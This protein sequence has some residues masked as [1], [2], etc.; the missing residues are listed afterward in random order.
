MDHLA[1]N[2]LIAVE[3]YLIPAKSVIVNLSDTPAFIGGRP[4][5]YLPARQSTVVENTELT[6]DLALSIALPSPKTSEQEFREAQWVDF[7]G[8]SAQGGANI[9]VLLKSPQTAVTEVE[10]DPYRATSGTSKRAEYFQIKLNLWFS[11]AGTDCGIHNQHDF[12]EVHTQIS[13]IGAMQKF[14]DPTAP[15]PYE[16]QLMAVGATSPSPFCEY[17][18]GSFSYPWHQYKAVT[19]SVWLAIEYH[20]AQ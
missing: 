19:D 13:G 10:M 20:R 11:P 7:Y 15:T 9:P 2:L 5:G 16:E 4:K 12:L 8:D 18:D 6:A 3:N 1:G 14:E 17:E